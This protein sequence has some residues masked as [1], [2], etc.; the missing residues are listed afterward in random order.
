[1]PRLVALDVDGTLMRSDNTLS[2]RNARA[3][4]RALA[5]GWRVVLATG[6]PP[7]AVE[8]LARQLGLPGPHIVA[9]G[10][11]LWR[12]GRPLEVLAR[13][14]DG[15]VRTALAFAARHGIPRAVSG[16]RGVFTQAGWGVPELTAA[17]REVGEAPPT[18]VADAVGAEPEPWKVILILRQGEPHPPAPEVE[19]GRWVRTH[20]AFY[21]TLPRG[22]SKGAALELL[23][24]RLGVAPADVVAFGDGENDLEMLRWAGLGVAMAHAPEALRRAA[25]QV[26]AGNDEDGVAVVLERLLAAEGRAGG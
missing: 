16:P 7:W 24:A 17:L 20:P 18:V 2:A 19:G 13:I 23:C 14:P 26:T 5:A 25:A 11:A 15:G 8:P 12:Q 4:A 21:E 1:M 10:S 3:L 22:A 9:N 6:K